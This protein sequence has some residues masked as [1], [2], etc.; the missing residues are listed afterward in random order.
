MELKL[1]IYENKKVVK[2]YTAETY[3]VMFGTVEDLINVLD[4]EK[5]TSGKDADLVQSVAAAIPKVFG[6]VKPLLK[7]IF[8][9]LTDDEL[10][11]CKLSD[12]IKVLSNVIKFSITQMNTGNNSKN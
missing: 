3:D 2:I 6:L 12:I 4:I 8:E 10:K 1:P 7:D 5:F 9:G 11:R